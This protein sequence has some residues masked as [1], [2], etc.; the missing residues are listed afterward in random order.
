VDFEAELVVIIGTTARNV[1]ESQ[2]LQHVYGYTIANDI[3]ARRWQK[4]DGGGQWVRGK[5]FDS[6]CPL[7]PL[8]ITADE[9]SNPQHLRI[10]S[11]LNG[12]VMQNSNTANMLFS[13][14]RLISLLS[15]DTTLLPGTAILTGTPA[16]VGF[17]RNPPVFLQAGDKIVIEI[18]NIG[19]L[20]NTVI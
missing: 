13:I 5:S 15:Q 18:E 10:A 6:F 11:I 17:T 12:V 14:A 16:G 20:E 4:Y 9:I 2:A 8:L 7:G 19:T 1:S 3:S